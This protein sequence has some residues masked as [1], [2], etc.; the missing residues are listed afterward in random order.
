M[1]NINAENMEEYVGYELPAKFLE[2][3]EVCYVSKRCSMLMV[4]LL[5]WCGVAAADS[6]VID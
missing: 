2:V 3:D 5:G 1:Q 4:L 6:H